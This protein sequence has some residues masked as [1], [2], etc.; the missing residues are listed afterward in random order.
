MKYGKKHFSIDE[1][2]R[3]T[4]QQFHPS[5]TCSEPSLLSNID[6]DMK[7]LM[8][9][10]TESLPCFLFFSWLSMR[11]EYRAVFKLFIS[12]SVKTYILGLN[13]MRTNLHK[14]KVVDENQER[15]YNILYILFHSICLI[16]RLLLH[17][18]RCHRHVVFPLHY[19]G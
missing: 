12:I 19:I 14:D 9:V 11:R 16:F 15:Q 8:A 1:N 10:C 18:L 5:A 17:R 3:D 13:L 4:Y 7:R 2:R 6:G